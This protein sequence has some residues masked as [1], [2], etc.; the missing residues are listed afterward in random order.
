MPWTEQARRDWA[1]AA[2]ASPLP[3]GTWFSKEVYVGTTRPLPFGF[4]GS[5]P[6]E[7]VLEGPQSDLISKLTRLEVETASVPRPPL[8]SPSRS[9]SPETPPIRSHLRKSQCPASMDATE[10]STVKGCSSSL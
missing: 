1:A 9:A 7:E 5:E 3:L 6:R 4:C 10:G 2:M 8:S